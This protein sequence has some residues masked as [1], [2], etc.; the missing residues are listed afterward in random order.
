[1]VKRRGWIERLADSADLQGEAFPGQPLVELYGD[2][3]VLIEHHGGVTEYGREKIQVKVRYG[4]LCIC[5]SCLELARMTADQLVITG[6]IDSVSIIR[7][8]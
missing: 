8:R 2:R 3:R 7:R 1:M 6:R 4:Y 5:G